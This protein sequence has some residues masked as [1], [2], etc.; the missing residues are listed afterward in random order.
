MPLMPPISFFTCA[1]SWFL[2]LRKLTAMRRRLPS[3]LTSTVSSAFDFS[4]SKL[5]ISWN[6][7]ASPTPATSISP[8]RIRFISNTLLLEFPFYGVERLGRNPQREHQLLLGPF[9]LAI[10]LVPRHAEHACYQTGCNQQRSPPAQPRRLPAATPLRF[11][12][13]PFRKALRRLFTLQ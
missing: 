12:D 13:Y 1:S 9:A 4:A 11:L 6:S 2:S 8:N 10:L 5:I 7:C 3:R